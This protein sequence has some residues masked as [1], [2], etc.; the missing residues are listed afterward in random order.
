MKK[1]Y[2]FAYNDDFGTREAVKSLLNAIP[3][4]THW[5][6]DMPHCF[7]VISEASAETLATRFRALSGPK[8]MFLFTEFRGNEQ[9]WLTNE[10]W[11]LINNKEYKPKT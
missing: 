8:G 1:A 7:Y 9:G 6:Y 3:E 5:R 10:S 2:L 11:H 4:I